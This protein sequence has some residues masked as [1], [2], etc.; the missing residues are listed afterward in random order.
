M[1]SVLLWNRRFSERIKEIARYARYMFND[2]LLIVLLIAIGGGGYYYQGWVKGLT[3]DFPTAILFALLFSFILVAGNV[4]TFFKEA[5]IVYLLPVE[6]KL[7]GYIKRSAT[8]SC[9]WHAFIVGIIFLILAPIYSQTVGSSTIIGF[10]L[11]LVILKTWNLL[12]K[13]YVDYQQERET[14]MIDT[15]VR[16]CLNGSVVYLFIKGSLLYLVVIGLFVIYG[17]YFWKE[18]RGH[19]IP[20]E[21][22]VENE[23]RRMGQFY[24]IANLFTDVP[25]LQNEV[26]RRGFL[27]PFVKGI[28]FGKKQTY[29]FLYVRAFL[30][31]GDYLGMFTRL[32][33]IGGLFIWWFEGSGFALLVALLFLYLTGYQLLSLYRH[34]ESSIWP[35]LYPVPESLKKQSFRRMLVTIL[36]VELGMFTILHF[37]SGSGIKGF[38]FWIIGLGYI[39]VFAFGFLQWKIDKWEREIYE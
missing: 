18:A 25:H 32:T 5:D 15:L 10:L 22:L 31:S 4:I 29:S 23:R 11:V 37:L 9:L 14:H 36:S 33:I 6:N 34:F 21:R 3:P 17:L 7:K 26:K 28:P 16:L 19:G 20:W 27:D 12:V 39:F 2:H 8:F 24:R 1:N 13:W 38:L 35:Q 30:R